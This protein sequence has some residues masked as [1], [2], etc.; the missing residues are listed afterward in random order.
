M[1]PII[2]VPMSS[3]VLFW[4][5][6]F[7]LVV[8]TLAVLVVPLLRRSPARTRPAETD[9]A[10]AIYRDQSRQLD[11]DVAAGVISADERERA[12]EEL[13]ARLGDELAAPTM[14]AVPCWTSWNTGLIIRTRNL[15]STSK[16]SG[17]LMSCRLIPR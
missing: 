9:A 13:V 17:A 3:T 2:P 16:Q 8:A 11:D 10:A 12:H 14:I 4:L 5:I 6:A 1:G 15:R 7:A